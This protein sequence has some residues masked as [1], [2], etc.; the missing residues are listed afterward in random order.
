ML[1]RTL[2]GGRLS[3]S[4]L[5]EG[6]DAET[7]SEAARAFAAGIL[8]EKGG[9]CGTCRSCRRA[10]SGSHLDLHLLSKDKPTVISVAALT[11]MLER[12][13]MKPS[14]GS[15]QVFVIEPQ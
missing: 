2:A 15:R 8:C 10:I 13:H 6:A 12:A 5:L 4:Y 11:P 3:P 1:R 7:L 9:A 14:E